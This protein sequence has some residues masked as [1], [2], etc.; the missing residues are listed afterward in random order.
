V[1][2]RR[3][4]KVEC[5]YGPSS[6]FESAGMGMGVHRYLR[7]LVQVWLSSPVEGGGGSMH[8]CCRLKMLMP[9]C[10]LVTVWS[11]WCGHG[12][13]SSFGAAIVI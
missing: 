11:S 1:G 12:P 7:V 3:Q 9:V 5:G 6:P 4:L 2:P 13:S 8:A 10:A